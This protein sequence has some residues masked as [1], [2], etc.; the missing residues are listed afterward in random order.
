M[1]SIINVLI[2]RKLEIIKEV[3]IIIFCTN[4]VAIKMNINAEVPMIK[5]ELH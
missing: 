3:S 5:K 1:M 2:L 4:A